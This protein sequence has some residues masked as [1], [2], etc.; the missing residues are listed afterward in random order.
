MTTIIISVSA[1]N[2]I[3]STFMIDIITTIINIINITITS[4]ITFIITIFI[5]SSVVKIDLMKY[6]LMFNSISFYSFIKY[7]MICIYIFLK[8][9]LG[10]FK[11]SRMVFLGILVT[12]YFLII[13]LLPKQ[14]IPTKNK[15][16][17]QEKIQKWP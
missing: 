10:L 1:T 9:P 5:I 7:S 2:I 11:L 15:L 13:V 8:M 3:I 14:T 12:V 17:K 16:T 4:F 6:F